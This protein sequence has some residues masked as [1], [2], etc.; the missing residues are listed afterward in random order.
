MLAIEQ[1]LIKEKINILQLKKATAK[2]FFAKTVFK[3]LQTLMNGDI[4]LIYPD[5]KQ[6]NFQTR[7]FFFI[8]AIFKKQLYSKSQIIKL[9]NFNFISTIKSLFIFLKFLSYFF[10][11]MLKSYY[12]FFNL[13]RKSNT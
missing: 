9:I 10:F 7:N 12:S 2:K 3:K 5:S 13:T 1:N 6:K 8:G 11:Q 4:S